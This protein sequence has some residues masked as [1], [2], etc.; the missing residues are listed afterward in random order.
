MEFEGTG[1]VVKHEPG[2]LYSFTTQGGITSTWTYRA[3]PEGKGTKLSVHVDY[4]V[5]ER[6]R[7]RLTS[8][9]ILESMRKAEAERAI[10]NLKVILDQ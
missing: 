3:E 5:P 1:R 9:P 6:A 10:Q 8:E 7:P 2:R 4:E